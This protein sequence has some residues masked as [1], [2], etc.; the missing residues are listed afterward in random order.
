MVSRI[1]TVFEQIMRIAAFPAGAVCWILITITHIFNH[2]Q[3]AVFSEYE[4]QEFSGWYR[5]LQLGFYLF[6]GLFVVL[7]F[8]RKEKFDVVT[9]FWQHFNIGFIGVVWMLMVF[10]ITQYLSL[11][12]N[13]YFLGTVAYSLCWYTITIFFAWSIVVFRRFIL[14]QK[15]SKKVIIW[16]IIQFSIV[17][18]LI[19][20]INP[21]N[22][23]QYVPRGGPGF[24]SIS[25]FLI[26]SIYF[27][28]FFLSS[29]L[30]ISNQAT[31]VGWVYQLTSGQK[32]K[33]LGLL[34]LIFILFVFYGVALTTMGSLF[35]FY[36]RNHEYLNILIII[37]ILGLSYIGFS[38]L[39]LF[40]NLP[41][42]SVFEVKN[43]VFTKINQAILTNLDSP[44]IYSTLLNGGI[45]L[46]DADAG[47]ISVVNT[48][49]SQIEVICKSEVEDY[50]I[51]KISPNHLF[52]HQVL[53]EKS[54]Y[55]IKRL[56]NPSKN[57]DSPYKSLLGVPIFYNNILYG[58][59]ILIK[60]YSNGFEEFTIQT[61]NS[62]AEQT[63]AALEHI[64]LVKNSIALERYQEQLKIAKELQYSLLPEQIPQPA[65]LDIAVIYD[66]A[67]EIGGDFYDFSTPD[68]NLFKVVIG[69]VSGHGT[70]AAFY[71]AV[72]KGI[73]QSLSPQ[74]LSLSEF[75]I[76][77]NEALCRSLQRGVF[78]TMTYVEINLAEKEVSFLRAGH[79]P[80]IFYNSKTDKVTTYKNGCP[81]L[82]IIKNNQYKAFVNNTE[83][84]YYQQGDILILLTD[85]ILEAKNQAG[86]EFGIERVCG[87]VDIQKEFSARTIAETI[88]R[89]VMAF[90]R[91]ETN[92]DD[93]TVCIVKF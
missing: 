56:Y 6:N 25:F 11:H 50:E 61:V 75:M 72:T 40:F 7:I 14:Y 17:I 38:M 49:N 71:M 16:N 51:E 67:E 66:Y 39:V 20:T 43:T 33:A 91:S 69:D 41:A 48:A 46:S 62:L 3:Q 86:E 59:L 78:V 79:C 65:G 10:F 52:T 82:G 70:T 1:Y 28:I 31:D 4:V 55:Y 26:F 47:W 30:R 57:T 9:I 22:I 24:T 37:L 88:R 2:S 34:L 93:M 15:N 21:L 35:N 64:R 89:E 76:H 92:E 53:L 13:I 29:G 60:K 54:P 77:A 42:S 68:K 81:G 32:L 73:F 45:L 87:I 5:L 23:Q 12:T 90:N 36:N 84:I 58:S 8:E 44:D 63:G 27:I 74:Q 85:G 19:L 83:E 18:G 80:T